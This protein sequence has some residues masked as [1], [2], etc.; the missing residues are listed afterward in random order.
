M[1]YTI[2]TAATIRSLEAAGIQPEQASA[3]VNAIIQSDEGLATKADVKTL[4]VDLRAELKALEA[5]ISMRL[6]TCAVGIVG[7]LL[8]AQLFASDLLS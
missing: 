7:L 8:A 5:R 2:D 6:Y 4:E 1:G 3:I